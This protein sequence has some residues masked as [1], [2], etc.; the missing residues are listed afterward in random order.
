MLAS[1]ININYDIQVFLTDQEINDLEKKS[2][3]GAI[4]ERSNVRNVYPLEIRLEKNKRIG[5]N[6][7]TVQKDNKYTI[8]ISDASPRTSYYKELK[9][10]RWIGTRDG[11]AHIGKIDI[12][13]ESFA[14]QYKEFNK[15]L[16]HSKNIW[17]NRKKIIAL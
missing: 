4:F 9:E 7:H 12:M 11:M 16:K 14:I 13:S 1:F 2:L 15:D 5:W 10:K 3:K 17:E 6:I 8:Y